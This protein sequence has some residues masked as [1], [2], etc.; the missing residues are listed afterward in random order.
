M[1]EDGCLRDA[2]FNT[3]QVVSGSIEDTFPGGAGSMKGLTIENGFNISMGDNRVEDIAIP[4]EETDAASKYYVD[5]IFPARFIDWVSDGPPQNIGENTSPQFVNLLLT[6]G[7]KIEGITQNSIRTNLNAIDPTQERN[8]NLANADGTLIPFSNPSTTTISATPEEINLLSGTTLGSASANDILSLDANRDITGIRNLS[9]DGTFTNGS[10]TIIDGDLTGV[11]SVNVNSFTFEGTTADDFETTLSVVDPTADRTINLADSSGTLIPF[12][13]PSTTTITATPEELN[14]L[15]GT[16]LGTAT[17]GDILSV[18]ANKDITG[19]RNITIDGTFTNGGIIIDGSGGVKV[20]NDSNGPGFVEFYENSNN[21]ENK[22][23]LQGKDLSDDVTITLP[24]ATGN[25]ISTGETETVSSQMLSS[26]GVTGGNYG[27]STSI[28]IL[29]IDEKGRITSASTS[30]IS[31]FLNISSDSGTDTISLGSDTLQFTGGTG[32][33]TSIASDTVTYSIDDTV[34]TLI[35]TQTLTNKTINNSNI[36]LSSE[37]TIDV[38]NST[39]TLAEG[40]ISGSK[41]TTDTLPLGK[42]TNISSMKVL[43]NTT[44]NSSSV[45]EIT[46]SN[47]NSLND[48]GTVISTQ[49]AIKYY[50]D[51]VASGLD[52]KGSCVVAT[53]ENISLNNTTTTIDG[54]TLSN[55]NRILVKDQI[56]PSENGIYIYSDSGTWSRS[57]DF[58]NNTTVT[59]GSFSF[60]E[61]GN[62]N[63]DSGFVVT[64]DTIDIENSPLEFS[65]FSG[66]GQIIPGNG[67]SKSGNTLTIDNS[68]TTLVGSQT[69]T[70]K[71]LTTPEIN[72]GTINGATI[73]TSNITVGSGKT[74]NVS[75]GTLTLADDQIS[76]DKVE[77][78]TISA[79]T[80]TTLTSTTGDI[81]NVNATTID[82]ANIEL[83]NIKARDGTSAATIEDSSGKITIGDSVLTTTEINGGTIDGATKLPQAI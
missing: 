45:S 16:T 13:T 3:L 38:Q 15:S 33:N 64:T 77:G 39:L 74:L 47:N 67:I 6:G 61:K 55:G 49:S 35:G 59:S 69:L 37:D 70:N 56:S 21:G 4:T 30:N 11:N 46:L 54:I 79:T 41:I 72:G 80:I 18:D 40:Q 78:G 31:T 5:S 20:K 24:G 44:E 12:S 52:V 26:T 2:V 17:A 51:S 50:I 63:V 8:I 42:I 27:S 22:I 65:Q 25:L 82:T 62:I 36:V 48:S 68:V 9:I 57:T 60:V 53:T 28:P 7:L 14:L 19:L 10:L 23:K 34:T 73:A 66:S 83:S 43:G 32:I 75:A 71:T 81:T 1:S 29:S 76:G 58:N